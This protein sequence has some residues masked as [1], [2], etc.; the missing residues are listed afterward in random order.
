MPQSENEKDKCVANVL[1]SLGKFAQKFVTP[2]GMQSPV[3]SLANVLTNIT[4]YMFPSLMDDMAVIKKHQQT[5]EK[6]PVGYH[7]RA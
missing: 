1:N 3:F 5:P 7:F 2:T 4:L 6:E